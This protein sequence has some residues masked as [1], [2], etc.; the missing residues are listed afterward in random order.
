[1]KI[2]FFIVGL[3]LSGHL[4]AESEDYWK[5]YENYASSDAAKYHDI[6]Q[7]LEAGN[8]D[9]AKEKL[10]TYQAAEVLVLEEMQE[11][12][13]ISDRSKSLIELVRKYNREYAE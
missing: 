13:G 7:S 11:Q 4:F 5:L 3:V 2:S 8:I 9:E 1:M 10:L 6:L 12:R